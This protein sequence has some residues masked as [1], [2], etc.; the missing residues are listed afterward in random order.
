[1]QVWMKH[2]VD[3]ETSTYS[4]ITLFDIAQERKISDMIKYSTSS[5][6]KSIRE[7]EADLKK[8]LYL[9]WKKQVRRWV[10]GLEWV[11]AYRK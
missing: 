10:K 3:L 9:V 6:L 5:L 1:M 7:A 11:C 2:E 4:R 8:G